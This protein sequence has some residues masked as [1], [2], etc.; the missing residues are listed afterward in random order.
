MTND[1]SFDKI[2]KKAKNKKTNIK[3]IQKSTQRRK[4]K[5]NGKLFVSK[6]EYFGNACQD[7]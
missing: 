5:K 4:L 1:I 6:L 7:W 2:F 3:K